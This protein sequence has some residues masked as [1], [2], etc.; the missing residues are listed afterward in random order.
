MQIGLTCNWSMLK[1]PPHPITKTNTKLLTCMMLYENFCDWMFFL[2]L[3]YQ[4]SDSCVWTM[5]WSLN[6]AAFNFTPNASLYHTPLLF[7]RHQ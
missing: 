7:F 2:S 1:Q 3:T 4:E 5:D 6:A